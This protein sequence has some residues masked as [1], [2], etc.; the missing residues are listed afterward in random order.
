M[1]APRIGLSAMTASSNA[2]DS[3]D[4]AM[5]AE[6]TK[7]LTMALKYSGWLSRSA[8]FSNQTNDVKSRNASCSK[9]DCHPACSAAQCKKIKTIETC[10]T[11]S[12]KANSGEWKTDCFCISSEP[13]C[14]GLTRASIIFE[15]DGFTDPD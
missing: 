7:V 8:L 10:G 3:E 12:R 5:A 14:A 6:N 11:S 1:T 15:E 13:S 9:N 4:P 2:N